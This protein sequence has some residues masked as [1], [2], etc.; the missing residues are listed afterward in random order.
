MTIC[1]YTAT[2]HRF[3]FGLKSE[4]NLAKLWLTRDP[5]P[6]IFKGPNIQ[7]S[8]EW[9]FE[10]VS[11]YLDS[12]PCSLE[13][14]YCWW[15]SYNTAYYK[16][17]KSIQIMQEFCVFLN[18]MLV[19]FNTWSLKNNSSTCFPFRILGWP[20]C[21]LSCGLWAQLPGPRACL[22]SRQP[23]T[24]RKFWKW[25]PP[26][27]WKEVPAAKSMTPRCPASTRL[28]WVQI[29]LKLLCSCSTLLYVIK[30]EQRNVV[31]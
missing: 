20:A 28:W 30:S 11:L 7:Y 31:L 3:L 2:S 27:N 25:Y 16:L 29:W 13:Q 14:V 1:E 18:I 12:L 24:P 9:L 15:L 21:L 22:T 19:H 23:Q 26:A 4:N 8:C 17:L 5:M 6:S 10:N